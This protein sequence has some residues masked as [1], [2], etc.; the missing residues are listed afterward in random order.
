MATAPPL[1]VTHTSMSVVTRLK[2]KQRLLRRYDEA[3]KF[4][5]SPLSPDNMNKFL[6]KIAHYMTY[7]HSIRCLKSVIGDLS[8]ARSQKALTKNLLD[9]SKNIINELKSHREDLD[10]IIKSNEISVP[11]YKFKEGFH[12]LTEEESISFSLHYMDNYLK[13]PE[14][15]QYVGLI[16]NHLGSIR[17]IL[18]SLEFLNVT[19]IRI[20]GIREWA[21]RS[22]ARLKNLL[23]LQDVWSDYLRAGD[24]QVL[25]AIRKKYYNDSF[26]EDDSHQFEISY[27]GLLSY[28]GSRYDSAHLQQVEKFRD[29]LLQSLYRFNHYLLD[30]LEEVPWWESAMTWTKD[31][32]LPT[33]ISLLIIYTIYYL[34]YSL[35]KNVPVE[36]IMKFVLLK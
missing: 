6:Y 21:G 3:L 9:A 35:G 22:E 23:T 28:S 17:S 34:F 29:D 24:F 26:S 4:A 7:A 2:Y 31:H 19:D 14:D 25:E 1:I 5:E 10:D 32:F 27:M 30:G 20:S 16:P 11:K 36:T 8:K 12:Q 33:A 18:G 15:Q 13:L